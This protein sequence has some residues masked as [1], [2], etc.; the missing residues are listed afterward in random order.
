VPV[1]EKGAS[2]LTRK[3]DNLFMKFYI[4]HRNEEIEATPDPGEVTSIRGMMV[5]K[6]TTNDAAT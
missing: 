5:R 2:L 6:V 3:S 1:I 4:A